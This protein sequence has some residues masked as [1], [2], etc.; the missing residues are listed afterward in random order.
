ML[1][2]V[3]PIVI[4]PNCC[5]LPAKNKVKLLTSTLNK[6]HLPREPF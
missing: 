6:A 5:V 3:M 1:N 4:G 2:V